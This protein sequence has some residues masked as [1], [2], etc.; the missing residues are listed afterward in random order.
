MITYSEHRKQFNVNGVWLETTPL[1]SKLWEYLFRHIGELVTYDEV[2]REVWGENYSHTP[3]PKSRHD[4]VLP[5]LRTLITRLRDKVGDDVI[6]TIM[7]HGLLLN[8]GK[9]YTCPM[10][11][12]FK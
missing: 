11:G 12:R 4:K 6:L 10:C 5:T 2:I 8:P 7:G 9:E 1:E 3:I